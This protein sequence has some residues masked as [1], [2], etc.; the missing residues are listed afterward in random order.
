MFPQTIQETVQWESCAH[1]QI[2]VCK[3]HCTEQ[4]THTYSTYHAL[5]HMETHCYTQYKCAPLHST[6]CPTAHMHTQHTPNC[7]THTHHS[8]HFLPHY[9]STCNKISMTTVHRISLYSLPEYA[10]VADVLKMVSPLVL[11]CIEW[12]HHGADEYCK[13]SS[14]H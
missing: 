4:H 7:C 13:Y 1:L 2:L 12:R 6:T 10:D 3:L 8:V 9:T 14:S 11:H 5:T